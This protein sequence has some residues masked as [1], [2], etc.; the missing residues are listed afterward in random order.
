MNSRLRASVTPSTVD[1]IM[2]LGMVAHPNEACGVI[3][4]DNTLVEIS[5]IAKHPT[6]SYIL[7]PAG[8]T[9]ALNGYLQKPDSRGDELY[10]DSIIIWHTHPG[11]VVGPS[12]GDKA[13]MIGDLRYLV[14]T[15]PS[16]EAIEFTAK[17]FNDD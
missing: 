13:E 10:M 8:F 17:D 11:G 4:P 14:V 12:D 2:E 15:L 16:G 1:K 9:N 3:L 7:D 5:N 6:W